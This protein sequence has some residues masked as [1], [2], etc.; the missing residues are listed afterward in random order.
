MRYARLL[1][2][3]NVTGIL[4]CAAVHS[5]VMLYIAA[6]SEATPTTLV[7]GYQYLAGATITGITLSQG[8]ATGGMTVTITG[9]NFSNAGT[10]VSFGGTLAGTPNS[11]PN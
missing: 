3:T 8:P 5:A 9:T 2:I 4:W 1:S 11:G 7:G 6:P 10:T